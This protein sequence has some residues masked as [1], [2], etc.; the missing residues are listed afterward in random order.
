MKRME[1]AHMWILWMKVKI[2]KIDLALWYKT[3]KRGG[4]FVYF[5]NKA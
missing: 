4:G 5:T 3:T 2:I 1:A